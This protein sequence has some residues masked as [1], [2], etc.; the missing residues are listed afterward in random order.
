MTNRA[1]VEEVTEEAIYISSRSP[2]NVTSKSLN[3]ALAFINDARA[4]NTA[5]PIQ[6]IHNY[7][8]FLTVSSWERSDSSESKDICETTLKIDLS[9]KSPVLPNAHRGSLA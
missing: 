2:M 6:P 9:S 3:H 8:K 4:P 5:K 7:Q 1:V